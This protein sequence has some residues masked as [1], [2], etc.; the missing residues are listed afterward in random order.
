MTVH[1]L[2]YVKGRVR[3]LYRQADRPHALAAV[4][5]A[6]LRERIR[7]RAMATILVVDDH[8]TNR[9]FLATLLGYDGQCVLEAIDALEALEKTRA[10]HPDLVIADILMP[11]IDGF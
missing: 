3:Q 2:I 9:E 7:S 11:T 1:T 5:Q 10:V 8:S 6:S 4:G